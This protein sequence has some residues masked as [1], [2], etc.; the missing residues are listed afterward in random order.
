MRAPRRESKPTSGSP[1]SQGGKH[2]SMFVPF[3]TGEEVIT[4][5]GTPGE[6]SSIHS[7]A[8]TGP[9]E[10]SVVMQRGCLPRNFIFV[11]FASGSEGF[12]QSVFDVRFP[13]AI[14]PRQRR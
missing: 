4:P 7:V 14:Q 1:T 6:P 3:G 13:P 2:G 9:E 8:V 5:T 12:C 10:M 11:I